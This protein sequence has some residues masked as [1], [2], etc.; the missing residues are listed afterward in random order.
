MKV[1][2]LTGS[3][4]RHEYFRMRI[5][6]DSRIDVLA[7]FCEGIEKSLQNRVKQ[8]TKS[9]NLELQHVEARFQAEIDFFSD[10]TSSFEDKS[11]PRFIPKGAINDP[12]IVNE[13]IKLKPDLLVCYGSSLIKSNLLHQF[14]GKFLNVHL[15]LS[16]YYR[17]CGTN[18]WP[19]IN[20]EPDMIGATFMYIDDGIDTGEIIHQI[21]A[22]LFVGDSPHSIGNR[23]IRTMTNTYADIIANFESLERPKQPS[24]EGKLYYEKDFD[25]DSCKKLYFNLE[26]GMIEEYLN[27]NKE[28]PYIAKNNGLKS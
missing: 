1:I 6:N 19:L 12:E 13:I 15:G 10:Y 18:V 4:I 14:N 7:T 20:N 8:N 11:I 21:R 5:S 26:Q 3:E 25:S 24:A 28:P 17:G 16:P 23:L 22:D 2:I 9:S 27:S